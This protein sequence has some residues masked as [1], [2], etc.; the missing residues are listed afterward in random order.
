MV[1]ERQILQQGHCRHPPQVLF[2]PSRGGAAGRAERRE[3]KT[4]AAAAGDVAVFLFRLMPDRVT[5]A[6]AL[7]EERPWPLVGLL[8][9]AAS[10]ARVE[11]ESEWLTRSPSGCAQQ[12]GDRPLTP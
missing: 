9:V 12:P 6:P 4:P 7:V 2:I 3:T 1:N 5:M 11:S 10:L 8:D